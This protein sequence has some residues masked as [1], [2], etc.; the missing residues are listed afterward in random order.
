VYTEDSNP[1]LNLQEIGRILRLRLRRDLRYM[2]AHD[3]RTLTLLE[4]HVRTIEQDIVLP[5]MMKGV[6]VYPVTM[7]LLKFRRTLLLARAKESM[8]A[9]RTLRLVVSIAKKYIEIGCFLSE[10]HQERKHGLNRCQAENNSDTTKR[11][12]FS[13]PSNLEIRRTRHTRHC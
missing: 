9:S 1:G 10:P 11:Y 13:T 6:G 8:V 2:A 7:T 3:R 4:E 12:K 5:L